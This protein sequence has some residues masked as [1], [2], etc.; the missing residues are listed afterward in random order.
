MIIPYQKY[1]F[2][3]KALETIELPLYKGSTF[4]GG[5]GNAFKK[6]VCVFRR[7]QC[8]ECLINRECAYSYIFETPQ[9]GTASFFPNE[10][11]EAVPHPFILEPPLTNQKIFE[12]GTELTF[13][14]I[15]I[16]KA[17]KYLPFFVMSFEY[18]GEIGIGKGR[19][20]YELA[21]I[22]MEGINIYEAT[23]RALT[24]GEPKLIEIPDKPDFDS[25]EEHLAIE[26]LTPTRLK[27]QR[28][29]VSKLE[30]F[31]LITNLLRRIALL[32]FY[33]HNHTK[34]GWNHKELIEKARSVAL[35]KD[36]MSW[37][38]WERYSHRQKTRLKLGGLVGKVEY[39]GRIDA[40][41]SLLKAGE[42]F[43]VGKGT[44][45]GLGQ[46]KIIS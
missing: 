14:L 10:K 37:I 25:N 42:I 15:L 3:L 39:K 22:T 18:L 20:K 2:V 11:Y 24:P 26:F 35:Q 6:V 45:F 13:T 8:S 9:P 43:H 34:P 1:Q 44:S 28:K 19:G 16:G 27:H 31:I 5:F 40:F 23:H 30:F 36:E 38:D 4:R 17:I 41:K 32:N 21:K 12:A 29:F 33:H 7:K 46:Y